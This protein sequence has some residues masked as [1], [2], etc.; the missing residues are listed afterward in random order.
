MV[1]VFLI[2]E[3]NPFAE[4]FHHCWYSDNTKLVTVPLPLTIL[5]AVAALAR[6]VALADKFKRKFTIRAIL[7]EKTHPLQPTLIFR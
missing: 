7:P 3:K 4:F 5:L 2:H 1:L 6:V